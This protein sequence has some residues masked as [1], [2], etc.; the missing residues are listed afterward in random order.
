M[1]LCVCP[2]PS[3]DAY[4]HISKFEMGKANRI[5]RISPYPGGKGTHVALA[6]HELGAKVKL[7]GMWAGQ[8]G[9][10]IQQACEEIGVECV[11]IQISGNS[12]RCLTFISENPVLDHT[13]LLEPGPLCNEA[14]WEQFLAAF[15][16]ELAQADLVCISGSLPGG[17]PID[18]YQQMVRLCNKLEKK[19]IL[20][21]SGENL[22]FS[23]ETGFWGLHLNE[24]E[25]KELFPE[26]SLTQAGQKLNQDIGYVAV[27]AGKEGL[28]LFH[29]QEV[30]HANVQIEDVISTVGSG[31]CLTAGM[32]YGIRQDLSLEAIASWGVA[33]G[34]ANCLTEELGMLRRADALR[35]YE[36]VKIKSIHHAA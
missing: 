25:V 2:N 16:D 13:E 22:R 11:G 35:L 32:A 26:L 31:D 20:D 8:T 18:G 28:W 23:L 6:L 24:H 5:T 30:I 21:C 15:E 17:A 10:W 36:K 29:N 27:T 14:Y 3:I 19:C 12:R 1:I 7:M 9:D 33:C 4:A 34:A